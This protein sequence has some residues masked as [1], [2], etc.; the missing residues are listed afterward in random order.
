VLEGQ[1]TEQRL[2]QRCGLLETGLRGGAEAAHDGG[3]QVGRAADITQRVGDGRGTL[4]P[5]LGVFLQFTLNRPGT[6][7]GQ[8]SLG[9]L[10]LGLGE[11]EQGPQLGN[12]GRFLVRHQNILSL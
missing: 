4:A 10:D 2:G 7:L 9:D 5:V 6:R 12:D 11:A 3:D 8:T 1:V